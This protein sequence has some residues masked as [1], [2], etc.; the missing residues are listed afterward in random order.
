MKMS[1]LKLFNP[2]FVDSSLDLPAIVS[3][4]LAVPVEWKSVHSTVSPGVN[5]LSHEAL[6]FQALPLN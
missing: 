2:W 1:G 3:K 6:L 4:V 5:Q